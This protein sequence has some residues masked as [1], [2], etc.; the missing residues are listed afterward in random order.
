[1]MGKLDGKVAVVTGGVAGIGLAACKA[2]LSE[3]AR[4]LMVDLSEEAL[5]KQAKAISDNNLVCFAADVSKEDETKDYVQKA[6]DAF[7]TID[8]YVGNAGI[9]G[10]VAPITDY[11]TEVFE[12]VMDVNVKGAWLGIKYV[13]PHIRK[14][15]KGSI[16]LISSIAGVKG[17]PGVSTYCASKHALK[18]IM[19]SV[20]IECA[21]TEIRVNT[22]HPGATQTHMIDLLEEGFGGGEAAVGRQALEGG[23]LN[24]RY[25]SPE[26]IS[27][28]IL[29]LA[30]DD[31]SYSTG[32]I[33]MADGGMATK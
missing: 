33:F 28:L 8:I 22:V 1:M 29:F 31:S 19:R 30:S 27:K 2:F 14:Q 3:G 18:G 10:P 25:A 17:F 23:T 20:A 9:L 16:I 15:R 7:G 21:G 13:L 11:P 6:M 12:R 5:D 26:E 32:S 24:G 4:V